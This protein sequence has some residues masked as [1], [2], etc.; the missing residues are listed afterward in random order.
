MKSHSTD[1]MLQ[2]LLELTHPMM[3][4]RVI[5]LVLEI[6]DEINRVRDHQNT[7]TVDWD[8]RSITDS[9]GE[10]TPSPTHWLMLSLMLRKPGK[11]LT[12]KEL[13]A[14]LYGHDPA[15]GPSN[16]DAVIGVQLHRLRRRCPWQIRTVKGVGYILEGYSGLVP[17]RR[18][19][20]TVSH[21]KWATRE[22]LIAGR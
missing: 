8:R 10:W 22:R 21:V 9:E 18:P 3:R 4:E 16:P 19:T 13:L 14:E 1:A 17:S 12:K 2:E 5:D 11:V 15:G 20:E 7:A 6:A